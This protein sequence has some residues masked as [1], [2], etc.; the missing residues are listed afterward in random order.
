MAFL[1]N[2]TSRLRQRGDR[3]ATV[4]ELAAG[5]A[6]EIRNPLTLIRG[7]VQLV[8]PE[9]PPARR[10]LLETALTDADMDDLI[11]QSMLLLKAEFQN[12]GIDA[13]VDVAEGRRLAG[14][15]RGEPSLIVQI[16]DTGHGITEEHRARVFDPFFTTKEGGDRTRALDRLR[17]RCPA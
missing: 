12:R 4:G 13:A 17:D 6:H 3:H 15:A 9:V 2:L 10:P 8:T 11:R 16:R 5:A 14:D 1:H 7:A